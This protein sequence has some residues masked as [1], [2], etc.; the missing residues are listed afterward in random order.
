MR[1]AAACSW[2]VDARTIIS[3][4]CI[5]FFKL[6]FPFVSVVRVNRAVNTYEGGLG[7]FFRDLQGIINEG[8]SADE[9]TRNSG[10]ERGR[11]CA[12]SCGPSSRVIAATTARGYVGETVDHPRKNMHRSLGLSVSFSVPQFVGYSRS[13]YRT[14]GQTDGVLSVP[15]CCMRKN[16]EQ[17]SSRSWR[18]GWVY[19]HRGSAG[20]IRYSAD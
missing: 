4:V 12:Q 17:E 2:V 13:R 20:P 16:I 14:D 8:E 1:A 9:Q 5:F 15:G 11:F 18:T 3:G 6:L 19:K 7:M 10:E